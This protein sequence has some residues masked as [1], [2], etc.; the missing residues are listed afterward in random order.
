MKLHKVRQA[1]ASEKG[2]T[3]LGRVVCRSDGKGVI[4][5]EFVGRSLETAVLVR[6]PTLLGS[7]LQRVGAL[8]VLPQTPKKRGPGRPRK[9]PP[10][11]LCKGGIGVVDPDEAKRNG[12]KRVEL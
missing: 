7:L 6:R 5:P 12:I 8:P 11:D 9:S 4:A 3:V 10:G 1:M 2:E